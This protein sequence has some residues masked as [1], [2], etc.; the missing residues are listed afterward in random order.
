MSLLLSAFDRHPNN[1]PALVAWSPEVSDTLTAGWLRQNAQRLVSRLQSGHP[2]HGSI[3]NDSAV[4]AIAKGGSTTTVGTMVA[5]LAALRLG[6]PFWLLEDPRRLLREDEYSFVTA[7]VH[8]QSFVPSGHDSGRVWI[9]IQDFLGPIDAYLDETSNVPSEPSEI[10]YLLETS[11][12][13]GTPKLV[14]CPWRGAWNRIQWQLNELPYSKANDAGD[15]R[16]TALAKTSIAFCDCIAEIW[17]P[18]VA[19]VPLI[20][21]DDRPAVAPAEGPMSDPRNVRHNNPWRDPALVLLVCQSWNVSHLVLTPTFLQEMLREADTALSQALPSLRYLHCSGEPLPTSLVRRLFPQATNDEPESPRLTPSMK[22]LNIYGSTE[23]S[24][25]VTYSVYDPNVA[26]D[27]CEDEPQLYMPVGQA[28]PGC[29]ILLLERDT[30]DT[31]GQHWSETEHGEIFVL[32]CQVAIGYMLQKDDSRDNFETCSGFGWICP[33]QDEGGQWEFGPEQARTPTMVRAFR[34]GDLGRRDQHG[35]L[36]ILGRIDQNVKVRGIRISLLQVEAAL[37]NVIFTPGRCPGAVVVV[38]ENEEKM[39][40]PKLV[41]GI[42][43]DAAPSGVHCFCKDSTTDDGC[44]MYFRRCGSCEKVARAEVEKW[45]SRAAV[46]HQI[47]FCR[48]E[49]LPRLTSGKIDRQGAKQLLHE[50]ST[51]QTTNSPSINLKEEM[52]VLFDAP[53][54]VDAWKTWFIWHFQEILEISADDC[55]DFHEHGGTSLGSIRL[56]FHIREQMKNLERNNALISENRPK[57]I[58]LH[59]LDSNTTPIALANFVSSLYAPS[60]SD[61]ENTDR[62]SIPNDSNS[63]KIDL[64]GPEDVETVSRLATQAFCSHEPLTSSLLRHPQR[65]ARFRKQLKSF[66]RGLVKQELSMVAR[67]KGEVV[68]FSLATSVEHVDRSQSFARTLVHRL[69]SPIFRLWHHLSVRLRGLPELLPADRLYS[70]LFEQWCAWRDVILAENDCIQI[71]MSGAADGCKIG[72]SAVSACES[73]VLEAAKRKGFGIAYTIC[74][75]EVTKYIAM[76]ELGMRRRVAI[77]TIPFLESQ[78]ARFSRGK[79]LLER[80]GVELYDIFLDER[81]RVGDNSTPMQHVSLYPIRLTIDIETADKLAELATASFRFHR[82]G[83]IS[84]EFRHLKRRDGEAIVAEHATTKEMLGFSF[85]FFHR[86][87]GDCIVELLLLAV[88]PK[89]RGRGLSGMLIHSAEQ[90]AKDRGCR[91]IFLRTENRSKLCSIYESHGFVE[92]GREGMSTYLS[93]IIEN[94]E[95]EIDRRQRFFAP[96]GIMYFKPLGNNE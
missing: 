87:P 5:M 33:S 43:T 60:G 8:D 42:A 34:T 38:L 6:W 49:N 28:L 82:P 65:S 86:G 75:N 7:V 90:L 11:G 31:N 57:K 46:P 70:N 89:H 72:A 96:G 55:S 85:L 95:D 14:Q 19:G 17:A 18:L 40:E 47:Y 24:A 56:L 15:I 73:A 69:G 48:T 91:H 66:C 88:R 23:V 41:A 81:A 63:I 58:T 20:V 27:D 59:D 10:L 30:S 35:Q 67:A 45:V 22:L 77:E 25:D 4:L 9:C 1:Q 61:Q 52:K 26:I 36:H 51:R 39:S 37:R 74:T 78:K 84:R 94:D 53:C 12:S 29:R 76:T 93:K 71:T 64:L 44:A 50:C 92:A 80:H 54:T 62:S 13:S 68:A 2:K 16:E 21:V 3:N 83:D 79:D 32:G